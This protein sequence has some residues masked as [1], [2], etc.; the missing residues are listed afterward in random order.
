MQRCANR[1][2]AMDV[3]GWLRR[4]GLEQYEAAFGENKIDD[5]VPPS[6]TAEDLKD[7]GVGFV[8]DRRKLLDA[9]AAVRAEAKAPT[10]LSDAPLATD[11]ATNDTAERRQVT[12][13]FSDLVGS[14]A[15]SARLD[16]ED[17]REVISAYQRCVAETV[18]R[19]GGFVA[20]YMGDGVLIYFGYPAAHEDN[21]ETS[22][23]V[24]WTDPRRR[25][26]VFVARMIQTA[27]VLR[28]TSCFGPSSPSAMTYLGHKPP[29]SVAPASRCT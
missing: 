11:N 23:N 14:T 7:L 12:V 29:R 3:G 18:R 5:T 17:L 8:G 25:F 26:G 15:L 13:M 24:S 10:P 19:F 2:A 22:R 1:G 16:P 27:L 9:I 4:L 20:R 6:L 28:A 21:K